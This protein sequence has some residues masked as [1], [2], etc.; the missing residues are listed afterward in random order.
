MGKSQSIVKTIQKNNNQFVEV[1][2]ST[3]RSQYCVLIKQYNNY[4]IKLNTCKKKL[5]N[6]H[7]RS[8]GKIF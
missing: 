4:P 3:K 6:I 1:S 8:L 7:E 5:A 2:I